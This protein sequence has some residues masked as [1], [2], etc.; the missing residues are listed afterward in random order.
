M[1][2]STKNTNYIQ[3]SLHLKYFLKYIIKPLL[4]DLARSCLPIPAMFAYE[5]IRTLIVQ[6]LQ[7]QYL[8]KILTSWI[9]GSFLGSRLIWEVFV[10]CERLQLQQVV[11][12]HPS[13]LSVLRSWRQ[14]SSGQY[15]ER[16]RRLAVLGC[17]LLSSL[18]CSNNKTRSSG[19]CKLKLVPRQNHGQRQNSVCPGSCQFGDWL[20]R[21]C[22]SQLELLLLPPPL[23]YWVTYSHHRQQQICHTTFQIPNFNNSINLVRMT[24]IAL[25]ILWI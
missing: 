19:C 14:Q 20:T 6:W 2:F 9:R 17:L 7:V 16:E 11:Q 5:S 10:A 18:L 22:C 25:E 24:F 15:R 12:S 1:S 21:P 8:Q 4:Q 13:Q 23:I 3:V